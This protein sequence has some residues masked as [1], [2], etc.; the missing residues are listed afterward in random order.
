M[1][2][3][4][5]KVVGRT[6]PVAALTCGTLA[7]ASGVGAETALPAPPQADLVTAD[8]FVSSDPTAIDGDDWTPMRTPASPSRP[9]PTQAGSGT[10]GSPT[11][12]PPPVVKQNRKNKPNKKP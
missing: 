9:N 4:L 3:H 8:G 7:L 11:V 12:P 1:S 6:V 5:W 10:P 2:H